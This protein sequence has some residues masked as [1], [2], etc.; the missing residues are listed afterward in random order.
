[1]SKRR[2]L[3]YYC[4]MLEGLFNVLGVDIIGMTTIVPLFLSDY[5]ASLALI[6]ALPS[7]Q[8]V[9]GAISPLIAGGFIARARSKRKLSLLF[10]GISRCAILVIP[11]SLLLHLPNA[12]V[13]A[14]FFIVMVLYHACQSITGISWNYLLG[15]CVGAEN[16]GKLLGTLFAFSGV[17]S[18]LSSNIVRLLRE[19]QSLDM[20]TRYASIF[21]LGGI[22][23]ACSVLFFIP[24]KEPGGAEPAREKFSPGAYLKNLAECCKDQFFRRLIITQAFATVST[25]INTFVY[26]IAQNY[27]NV[28]TEW[29]SYMIIIQTV[30]VFA[31][32]LITGHIS[33]RFGSKRTLLLGESLGLSIPILELLALRFGHGEALLLCAAFLI[34]FIRSGNMAYQ[35]H[36]LELAKQDTSIFYIVSKSMLLLPFTFASIVVGSII[37]RFSLPPVLVFQIGVALAAVF[38]ASRLRLFVYHQK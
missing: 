12:Q 14:F 28:R 35:S 19:N 24:L 34:G 16:R 15:V 6:G 5:G 38:C 32:G 13:I 23:I 21:A 3:N 10:N 2:G 37:E 29:I 36:L 33:E 9:I 18:F 22:L 27:L 25:A 20:S 7:A 11:L 26:I 8:G 17:I 31:G 30:G 1:M 4:I